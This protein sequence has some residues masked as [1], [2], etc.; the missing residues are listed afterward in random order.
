[1][2][3]FFNK[4]FNKN[5]SAKVLAADLK[6]YNQSRNTEDRTS[7][8]QAPFKSLYFGN[9]G[10]VSPCCYNRRYILGDVSEQSIE[11]IWEDKKTHLLR[12]SLKNN[13]LSLGCYICEQQLKSKNYSTISALLYDSLPPENKFPEVMEFEADDICNLQCVMCTGEYSSAIRK[14]RE[15]KWPHENFYGQN[16]VA[17]LQPYLKNLKDAKFNGGEPF[18]SP[19]YHKIWTDIISFNPDC[20]ISVQT[21]GT[22]LNDTIKDFLY[23]GNFHITVSLDALEKDLY[24]RIRVNANYD[25]VIENIA[26]FKNYCHEKTN[27]FGIAV[28]PMRLNWQ[29]MPNLVKFANEN[30]AKIHFH[31]VW[32]PPSLALWNLGLKKLNDIYKFLNGFKFNENSEIEKANVQSYQMLLTQIEQWCQIAKQRD[33]EISEIKGFINLKAKLIES[34]SEWCNENISNHNENQVIKE[35]YFNI[36]EKITADFEEEELIKC[37]KEILKTP[38]EFI[39]STLEL[40]DEIRIM[41]RFKAFIY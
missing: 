16:F 2:S 29:E 3:Y 27:Y 30:K 37:L 39:I 10:K 23:K 22:I 41:E 9:N 5:A 26:F 18:L 32:F 24:E 40:A 12:K 35:K 28:C 33:V 19:L 34:V 11:N 17:Q 15:N 1:M 25:K 7:F 20:R 14:N 31:T 4:I 38:V 13:D 8:C 6:I 36:I 21:N